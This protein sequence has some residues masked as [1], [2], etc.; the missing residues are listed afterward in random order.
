MPSLKI[1]GV[2]VALTLWLISG[3]AT[4][5]QKAEVDEMA[6]QAIRQNGHATVL[7]KLN[8]QPLKAPTQDERL[9]QIQQLEDSVLLGLNQ[10]D[11]QLRYRYQTVP[12]F[13]ALLFESGLLKLEKHPDV[14]SIMMDREGRGGLL[15]SVPAIQADIAHDWGFTGQGVNV[16]VLDSGVDLRHPDLKDD[17]VFEYH[18][19]NQG[20][21]VGPGAQDQHGH[22]TNVTG[23]ITSDGMIAPTGVA[24]RAK[25]VAIRVLDANASGWLSDWVAGVDYI[26]ANNDTL[27]VKVINMSLV[28]FALY[29]GSHCDAALPL[30]ATVFTAAHNSGAVIFVSSGNN[31]STNSMSAPACLSG[32]V[33]VGA[34]YDSDL[35]REP[36][37]GTYR[38]L[39][40]NRWPDCADLT[41][42][43]QTLTCFTNRNEKLGLVAP[44]SRITSTGLGSRRSTFIG[45]SQAS[46]HAAGVAALMLQKDPSLTP[47]AII[48]T[49]K[50]SSVRVDDPATEL[51][52]PLLNAAEALEQ[53][54]GPL[55]SP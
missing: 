16:A 36:D 21:D 8:Q 45:T 35:G 31:G 40:G 19:L 6:R 20:A 13:S 37:S 22:G 48:E 39:F 47:A 33:A 34:V 4:H 23:I 5:G 3:R 28:T 17:I 55:V 53:V 50:N 11:L 18:F 38:T 51:S 15:E 14:E 54:P 30:P 9:R 24:P 43:L 25:I 10:Q 26:V 49:M 52:F 29:K 44:G 46:P 42:S 27:N 12:G 7:V 32:A 1:F 2:V 41:T